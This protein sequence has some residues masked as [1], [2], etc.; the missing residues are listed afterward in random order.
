[1]KKTWEKCE[2]QRLTA[3]ISYQHP[4]VVRNQIPAEL[5]SLLSLGYPLELVESWEPLVVSLSAVDDV[6]V[7]GT[8]DVITGCFLLSQFDSVNT[9]ICNWLSTALMPSLSPWKPWMTRTNLK[10]NRTSFHV[11]WH[12]RVHTCRGPEV[13]EKVRQPLWFRVEPLHGSGA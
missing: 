11:T 8:I 6:D 9:W 7:N 10:C 13:Q 1:M 4:G 5:A 12:V 3:T 2:S